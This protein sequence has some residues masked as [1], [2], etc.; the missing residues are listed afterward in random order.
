M[1]SVVVTLFSLFLL[2]SD[3]LLMVIS[4]VSY[5]YFNNEMILRNVTINM[6]VM[7]G[8]GIGL[9][10]AGIIGILLYLSWPEFA[11]NWII[12]VPVFLVITILYIVYC[13]PNIY[14]KYI[15][16]YNEYWNENYSSILTFQW[17]YQCCGYNNASDRAISNCPFEFESGCTSKIEDY[18]KRHLQE[19]FIAA[20]LMC[21]LFAISIIVLTIYYCV[22][23]TYDSST[24]FEEIYLI[25]DL[26]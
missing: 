7:F 14:Q 8:C 24:L 18:L 23:S 20:I 5:S 22:H 10:I 4:G 12:T 9:G 1:S 13:R 26:F 6:K 21:G 11:F 25:G 2:I 15:S 17:K 16:D 19:I 3:V